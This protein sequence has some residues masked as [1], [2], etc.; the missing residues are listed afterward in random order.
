VS[1]ALL[2]LLERLTPAERGVFVLREAFG[3]SYRDI[4]EVL[5]LSE[6]NCR[7]IHRNLIEA[8]RRH[9]GPHLVYLSIVGV[10]RVPLGYYRIKLETERL[11]EGSGLPWT[12]LRATQFHDLILYLSQLLASLPVMPVP[13]G[14]SFQPVDAEDV[15]GRVA[16]SRSAGQPGGY[17]ISVA[18]RY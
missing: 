14:T 6:V 5:G 4:G 15:A 13:A 3:Y 11:I 9:G 18:P 7:Q 12:T 8:A 17:R 16:G 2:A 1:L 10:D